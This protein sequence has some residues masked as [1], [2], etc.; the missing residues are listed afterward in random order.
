[1]KKEEIYNPETSGSFKMMFG[2]PQPYVY[3][4]VPVETRK[5]RV[6]KQQSAETSG[7]MILENLKELENEN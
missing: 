6:Y 4:Y 3:H 5:P 1:M 2:F 7:G